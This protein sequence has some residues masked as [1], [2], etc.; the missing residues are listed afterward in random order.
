MARVKFRSKI[1]LTDVYEQVRI[2]VAD[3]SKTV[4]SLIM[5]TYI[6]N[7]MQIE[8]YNAS[9]IFQRLMAS[10]FYN[11]IGRFIHIYLDNIF[12]YSN[13]IEEHKEYLCIIFERLRSNFLYLK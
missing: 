10:I 4:F 2:Y 13:T 8:N 7:I 3:I 1:N 11:V 6:S 12:I 9:A 5:E